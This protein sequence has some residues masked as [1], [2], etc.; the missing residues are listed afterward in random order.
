MPEP[1]FASTLSPNL[2]DGAIGETPLKKFDLEPRSIDRNTDLIAPRDETGG[3][4]ALSTTSP[5]AD[6]RMPSRTND[7]RPHVKDSEASAYHSDYE[8]ASDAPA[9]LISKFGSGLRDLSSSSSILSGLAQRMQDAIGTWRRHLEQGQPPKET[10]HSGANVERLLLALLSLLVIASCAGA[11]AAIMQVK[12]LKSE[13][14]AM[15]RELLPLRER[16]ARLDQ[17]VKSKEALDKV[18]GQNNQ[19]SRENRV[20]EVPLLLSREEIQLVRD[21]IKPAPLVDASTAPISV[22]DPVTGPTIPFPSALTEKI[23]KL[24]GARFA[25]QNG[26]II[27]IKRDSRQADAVLGAN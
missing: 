11:I 2:I 27:I 22:G 8:I 19:P 26:A 3:P 9:F 18:S 24:I 17:V 23:S 1:D 4:E 6:P 13:L 21:Y 25:I 16:V 15:Q 20:Q 10:R 7:G 5:P 12:S 14:T